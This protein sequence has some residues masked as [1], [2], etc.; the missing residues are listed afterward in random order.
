MRRIYNLIFYLALPAILIRLLWRSRR[1]PAYRKGWAERLGFVSISSTKPIIW[2]HAVSL[3]ESIAATPLIQLL[4]E[5]YPH[6]TLVITNMTATGAAQIKKT[7]ADQVF[8]FFVPYDFPGAVQRFLRK[9][10]PKLLIIMETEL[11]PNLLH[12]CQQQ[13]IPILIANGRLSERSANGYGQIK[14][15]TQSMLQ[16]L[17]YIAA[18]SQLDAKHFLQL[19]ANPNTTLTVGNIKFDVTPPQN[20]ITAGKSLRQQ[21]GATNPIWIAAST[22]AGEEEIILAAHQKICEKIPNAKLILVPR[23]P[24]RFDAIA[25]L[26]LHKNYRVARRSEK[27]LATN[28]D[29]YLGDSVGELWL[30]YASADVAFVGGSLSNIGGHNLLEPAALK[31]PVISGPHLHNFTAIAGLFMQAQALTIVKNAQELSDKVSAFL[32]NENLREDKGLRGYEVVQAN[33]GALQRHLEIIQKLLP[34][35]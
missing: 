20:L 31:L 15:L 18:Q 7:F 27:N 12:Y 8:H 6:Y 3:G 13:H 16:D 33:Q 35:Q 14:S 30:M 11:W 2:L 26:C 4:Q 24:E 23:H 21:L 10:K 34:P 9:I 32:S 1:V 5:H 28:F 22:H 25:E 19:G 29:I 17:N